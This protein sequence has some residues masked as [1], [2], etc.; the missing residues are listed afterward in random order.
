[1]FMLL[2]YFTRVTLPVNHTFLVVS[3]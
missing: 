1:M 3:Y 2:L